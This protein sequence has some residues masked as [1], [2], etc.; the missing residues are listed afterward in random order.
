MAD[1]IAEIQSQV[2]ELKHLY[3]PANLEE[4]E[5][6]RE[7]RLADGKSLTDSAMKAQG[8]LRKIDRMIEGIA[9][10]LPEE[11]IP[12]ANDGETISAV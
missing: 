2:E 12:P 6:E 10:A 8:L 1:T 4:S 3:D 11:E 7:A 5:A 9:D